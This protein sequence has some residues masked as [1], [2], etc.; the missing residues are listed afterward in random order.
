MKQRGKN[1]GAT[2]AVNF[3]VYSTIK[4]E[5]QCLSSAPKKTHGIYA[6]NA[7]VVAE[8][9]HTLDTSEEHSLSKICR[10]FV[11]GDDSILQQTLN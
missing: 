4:R 10:H 3:R 2:C 5:Q 11:L 6:D 7:F 9:G 8:G 1:V